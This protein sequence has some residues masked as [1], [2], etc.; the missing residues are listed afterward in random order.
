M[1]NKMRSIILLFMIGAMAVCAAACAGEVNASNVASKEESGIEMSTE[2]DQI[3]T[4][5]TEEKLEIVLPDEPELLGGWTA[6]ES[7]EVTDEVRELVRNATDGLLGVEYEP[8]AY[9]GSQ[10][11]AGSNHCVLCKASVVVPNSKPYYV[12][13]YIYRDLDGNCSIL[14]LEEIKLGI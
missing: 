11:V 3:D 14:K 8:V 12:F 2:I 7:A 6:S 10:L 5:N 9:L 13:M 4:E 1:K